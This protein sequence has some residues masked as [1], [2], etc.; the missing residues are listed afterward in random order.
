MPF[1]TFDSRELASKASISLKQLEEIESLGLFR[2]A[3]RT[4]Q[5]E[6]VY[7]EANLEEA[8]AIQGLLALGYDLAEIR[9]IRRKVGMPAGKAGR[10]RTRGKLLTVG[11]VAKRAGLNPRTIKH[12]EEQEVISPEAYSEGGFRLYSE[13]YVLFCQLIRDLQHFGFSLKEI[14]EVAD[15]FREYHRISTDPEVVASLDTV[16]S[17]EEML[18]RIDELRER[19]R[20]LREGI[21]RWEGFTNQYSKRIGRLK[22]QVAKRLRN[23]QVEPPAPR[24]A[25]AE[26]PGEEPA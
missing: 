18:V 10:A 3:A 6:A 12:W 20:V 14:K 25:R 23:A 9:K 1:R 26:D 24:E 13:E 8:R 16:A 19:M 22:S 15:L 11:E 21:R 7:D 4:E 5:G 17:L 2:P